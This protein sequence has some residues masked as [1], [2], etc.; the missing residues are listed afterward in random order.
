MKLI[1]S[2]FS[3]ANFW[4]TVYPANRRPAH[5]SDPPSPNEI[6]TTAEE[7]WSLAPEWVTPQFL[8]PENGILHTLALSGRESKRTTTHYSHLCTGAL[9]RGALYALNDDTYVCSPEFVFIQLAQS[10]NLVQLVAF[11]CELCGTFAFNESLERGFRNRTNPL[12][13]LAQLR[14]FVESAHG[15]RGRKRALIA[16]QFI[17]ENAASPMEATCALLISLPYRLG[18]YS[19]PKLLLNTRIDIP[20]RLH[21]LFPKGYCIVDFRI[22]KTKFVLEY[23][24]TH[25]HA[26]S[27]SLQA[28]RGRTAALREMGYEVV[29]L[30]SQQVWNL[31]AFEIIAKQISK[32]ANKRIR[33]GEQGATVARIQLRKTLSTWNDASG[34]PTS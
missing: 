5:T 17:V 30:T 11:G 33:S 21:P 25:D 20:H 28:D 3:A 29:E 13:S 1:I 9:P 8:L 22:P 18:G 7:V 24:G 6:A 12:V 15:M 34:R 16:I 10:L 14:Q 31:A 26:N 4:R 27:S 19:L 32:A 2:H 23:L